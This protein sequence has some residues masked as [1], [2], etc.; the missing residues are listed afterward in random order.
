MIDSMDSKQQGSLVCVG[1]GLNLAGQITVL[2]Q[3]YIEH[4]EVVF[5][6]MPDGFAERWVGRL[7]KDVRSLQPFYAQKG[8]VKN[9]RETYAQMVAAIVTQV[10]LGKKVVCALYGHPGVF[11]CVGHMAV[12]QLQRE[13]YRAQ[14]EPGVSAE[15]CLWA[16]L[17]VDPA[18]SGHQSFEASQF[19]YYQHA[20]SA[21]AYL[22]LWQI[23]LA[24][25]HTLTKFHTTSDKLQ[26]LV[27][28]LQQWYPLEHEIII[29][30]AAT[31]P[32]QSPRI[33]TLRLKDLPNARLTDISTLCIPP[34]EKLTLNH[35]ALTQLGISA[36]DFG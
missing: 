35:Q 3:S 17:G 30:E 1:T 9:R 10:Y 18:S 31:L 29:Y 20:V 14:M 23:G 16:D 33:E 2:S 19:M 6:L 8:E 28:L 32:I 11:A 12:E 26:V 7:N 13:G 4:A 21:A 15:A 22:V 5:T 24:G 27:E 25:E 36:D 34:S